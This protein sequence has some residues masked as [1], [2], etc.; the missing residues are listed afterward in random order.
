MAGHHQNTRMSKMKSGNARKALR[1]RKQREAM[2]DEAYDKMVEQGREPL[3]AW[4]GIG[5]VIVL[6][7]ILFVVLQ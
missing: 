2:G 1:D 4:F 5:F 7:I 3:F 6:A